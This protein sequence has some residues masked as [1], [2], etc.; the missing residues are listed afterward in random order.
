[1][2]QPDLVKAFSC[3]FTTQ[4]IQIQFCWLIIYVLANKVIDS[5]LQLTIHAEKVMVFGKPLLNQ[6]STVFFFHC[7]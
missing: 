5:T 7:K 2:T 6:P 1:M 4:F 3:G